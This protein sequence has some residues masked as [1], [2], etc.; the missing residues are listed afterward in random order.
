[1]SK[2]EYLMKIIQMKVNHI[3]NPLGFH[4]DKP[5]FSYKVTGAEGKKQTKARICIYQAEDMEEPVFDSGIQENID[6]I[7]YEVPIELQPCTRYYWNVTVYT[8]KPGESAISETAWFETG[9][10]KK[11]WEGKWVYSDLNTGNHPIYYKKFAIEANNKGVKTA[12]LYICG[13]GLYE[14]YIN[15]IKVSDECLTPYC[16]SYEHW[17][18][19]QTY[20]VTKLLKGK[21]ENLIEV[22]VGDGWYKGRFGLPAKECNYGDTRLLIGELHITYLDG[23][24][25]IIG[26]NDLW[27]VRKSK[28]TYSSIYDG[29]AFDE[30][31]VDDTTYPVYLYAKEMP[32]LMERFSPAVRVKEEVVPTRLLQSPKGEMII[33]MGQIITGWFT[34]KADEPAGAQITLS[35]FEILQ[36]GCY[37]RDNLRTAKQE[38]TYISD[39]KEK[40]V[41]P[42]FTYY[43]YRYVKIEGISD[44]KLEDFKGLVLHS[45]LQQTG[46]LTTG[47]VLINRLILN[48]QWSQKCNFVDVPTDCPQRDERLGWTGDAQVFS[49]T[50]C[51]H[52]D[53]Y[54]FYQKYLHDMY[55]EQ[56]ANQG[57]VPNYVPAVGEQKCSSVWGDAATI[58]PWNLYLFY[59]DKKILED[60]FESMKAWVDYITKE[61][62]DNWEWR[63]H[64]HWG[65]WLALDNDSVNGYMGKTD[66]GYIATVYYFHSA[67]LVAKAAKVIGKALEAEKYEELA[68]DILKE[69]QEE[70]F[71]KHGRLSIDTQTGYVLALYYNLAPDHE[72]LYKELRYRFMLD[73]DKLKT[74][75]VGTPLLCNTLSENGM[76]DLAYSLVL[77]EGYP[78]WLYAVKMGATTIWERWNSVMPD[79]KMN[80]SGMNSLNHYSNGSIVEW[81]YRHVAGINPIEECPGFRI[82]KLSPKPDYRLGCAEALLDSPI[83]VYRSKWEVKTD[84]KLALEF[85]VP[86]G[87]TAYLTLPFAPDSLKDTF[88]IV[89]ETEDG[90][91]AI[92]EAGTYQI[93][94]E[95]TIP[96]R[97]IFS[98]E[99]TV[100]ELLGNEKTRQYI[101][102]AVPFLDSLPKEA[103]KAT[104]PI[105]LNA[106]SIPMSEQQLGELDHALK[107][108]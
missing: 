63:T 67:T 10:M 35:L 41:R 4:M 91:E 85:V 82:V 54:S 60:Q 83:G 69:I 76:N 92:L 1:M 42:H 37:Y 14:A 20:D 48:A 79:G 50:A 46:S 56:K 26:T 39:G 45:D 18:Q 19:Y 32:E 103:Y 88:E 31:F 78:G 108:M 106:M 8:N 15:D 55:E 81:I 70:Y 77:E 64:Y 3:K 105:L 102:E 89:K 66:T 40:V 2:E 27:K 43:G 51:Y 21:Q 99:S 53:C 47:N 44:L 6:S 25:E 12:R 33:D 87:G 23:N 52:M 104:I 71:T 28:I 90:Y 7:A 80:P 97:K 34:L 57:I 17:L 107:S 38:Y 49:P 59:G 95:P 74:G 62:G 5:V 29:E 94:Y 93:Q 16:N 58:I 30:T 11:P 24:I 65:D 101:A 75:F 22:V 9:K 100:E 96:M 61:N 73:G 98:L 72:R 86:F 36:D 84:G 68:A 13:L